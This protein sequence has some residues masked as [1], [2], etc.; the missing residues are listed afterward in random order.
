M[1]TIE[2]NSFVVRR[3]IRQPMVMYDSQNITRQ[4]EQQG[5]PMTMPK[6]LD[7]TWTE[8]GVYIGWAGFHRQ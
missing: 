6:N 8:A 3:I 5:Y 4:I 1:V 7:G 2:N